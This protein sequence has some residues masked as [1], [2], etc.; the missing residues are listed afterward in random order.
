MTAD[1]KLFHPQPFGKVDRHNQM[2]RKRID[3]E[4]LKQTR[5]VP[6]RLPWLDLFTVAAEGNPSKVRQEKLLQTKGEHRQPR[7]LD[8]Y[9]DWERKRE[10]PCVARFSL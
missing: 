5:G 4:L 6:V 3:T 10:G 7:V 9:T 1:L 2:R 8:S